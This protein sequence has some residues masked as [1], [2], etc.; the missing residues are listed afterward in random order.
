L[1]HNAR[2]EKH[3]V[4]VQYTVQCIPNMLLR[5]DAIFQH[6]IYEPLGV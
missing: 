2:Y 5:D 6:Y 4:Y 3:E 1:Y